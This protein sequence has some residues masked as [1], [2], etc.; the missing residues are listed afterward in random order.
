MGSQHMK[1]KGR[2]TLNLNQ[3]LH[4]VTAITTR[5]AFQHLLAL[6]FQSLWKKDIICNIFPKINKNTHEAVRTFLLFAINEFLEHRI[7]LG[8]RGN[9]RTA[10]CSGTSSMIYQCAI[11]HKLLHCLPSLSEWMSWDRCRT[12]ML[13]IPKVIRRLCDTVKLCHQSL[14]HA[15]VQVFPLSPI[16]H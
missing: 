10:V 8:A 9:S 2:Y 4:N 3:C 7:G 14:L 5:Y 13:F 15:C 1:T 12:A 6:V 16:T 11:H